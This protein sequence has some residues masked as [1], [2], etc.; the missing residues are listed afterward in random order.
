MEPKIMEPT[1]NAELCDLLYS[2]DFDDGE[3][4]CRYGRNSGEYFLDAVEKILEKYTYSYDT[5]EMTC[6]ESP[7][8]TTGAFGVS[9]LDDTNKEMKMYLFQWVER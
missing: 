4:V 9:F 2:D 3:Y 8:F 5:D 6:F 1:L 7:G